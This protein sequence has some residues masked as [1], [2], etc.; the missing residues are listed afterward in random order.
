MD[1]TVSGYGFVDAVKASAG[2]VKFTL[3]SGKNRYF[4]TV[5][6]AEQCAIVTTAHHNCTELFVVGR[7]FSFVHNGCAQHHCG[8]DAIIV[9][10]SDGARYSSVEQQLILNQRRNGNHNGKITNLA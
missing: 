9:L 3:K 7:L 8:I 1:L 5:A 2:T 10:H 6:G 4:V